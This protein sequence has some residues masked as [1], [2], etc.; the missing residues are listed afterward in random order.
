MKSA[1]IGSSVEGESI[2]VQ[3][4][5]YF[6]LIP[7]RHEKLKKTV[8]PFKLSIFGKVT[9]VKSVE[10]GVVLVC[11]Q[12]MLEVDDEIQGQAIFG[13][14]SKAVPKPQ[15][16]NAT[17]THKASFIKTRGHSYARVDTGLRELLQANKP[18]LEQE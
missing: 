10:E 5:K 17:G 11:E 4:R 16:I 3:C 9:I 2:A 1:S 7:F 12:S 8:Y 18:S 6:Q 13:H 14:C 15:I